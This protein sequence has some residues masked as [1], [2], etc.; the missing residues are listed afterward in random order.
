MNGKVFSY[1]SA[2]VFPVKLFLNDGIIKDGKIVPFHVQLNPTNRCN[3]KCQFCSCASREKGLEMSLEDI[4]KIMTLYARQ[5]CKAVTITGGGEPLLH[6]QI[7]E[8]IKQIYMLGMSVGLVTNGTQLKKLYSSRWCV[9]WI[10]ISFDDHRSFS[11]EFEAE[12]DEAVVDGIDWAF[13]YVVTANPNIYNLRKVIEFANSH[14]FTHVR[15][16]SDL[17]DLQNAPSMDS[18][19]RKLLEM[20]ID[21]SKVI[22]QGRKIFTKGRSKCLISLSKPVIGADGRIYPCCGIQY[23]TEIPFLDYDESMCMGIGDDISSIY[24]IQKYFDGSNCV[25]C[26]YDEYN[27]ALEL[28]TSKL[29]H[30]VFV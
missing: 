3:L 10:R 12:L 28:L 6:W 29:K 8:M 2:G 20:G 24:K 9:K 14:N 16:V 17:L 11:P 26:Y 27:E 7:T 30:L 25:R 5:G 19:K 22:Y 15:I 21:D 1:T 18:L 13:S 23:A 4:L